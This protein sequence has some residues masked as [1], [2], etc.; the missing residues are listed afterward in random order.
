[1]L[2]STQKIYLDFSNLYVPADM[3]ELYNSFYASVVDS[4]KEIYAN[5]NVEIALQPPASGNYT[6]I[7]MVNSSE[8]N[9]HSYGFADLDLTFNPSDQ[10]VVFADHVLEDTVGNGIDQQV[11]SMANT[12]GHEIGHTLGLDHS[13]DPSNLMYHSAENMADNLLSL[14][15]E[16]IRAINTNAVVANLEESSREHY[17]DYEEA[18]ESEAVAEESAAL[19][20]GTEETEV[21]TEGIEELEVYPD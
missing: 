1:M 18:Y 17:G 2:I 12:V 13:A 4:V 9:S 10:G 3:I 8:A 11:N 19:S 7:H 21:D 14:S 5:T 6:T 20:D 16:Q 15:T